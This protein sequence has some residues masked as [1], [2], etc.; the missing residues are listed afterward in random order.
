M[1]NPY[2][3]FGHEIEKKSAVAAIQRPLNR[4]DK[5]TLRKYARVHEIIS[6][7]SVFLI[8]QFAFSLHFQPQNQDKGKKWILILQT[9]ENVK[10]FAL[11]FLDACGLVIS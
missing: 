7:A 3:F 11:K 10:I 4:R 8:V 2:A 9:L 5:C 6:E 1:S